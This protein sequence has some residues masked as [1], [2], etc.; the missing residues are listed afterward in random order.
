MIRLKFDACVWVLAIVF[1]VLTGID[2]GAQAE[3][4]ISNRYA[5]N[6]AGCHSP[7]RNNLPLK[8]RRCTLSCQGC[9][10]SPNGGGIRN[11]YGQWNQERWL[12]TFDSKIMT[13][14]L[15][16]APIKDQNY[17]R[18]P[19]KAMKSRKKTRP[20][21]R[22]IPFHQVNEKL[23]DRYHDPSYE[24]MVQDRREY[25]SRIPK[26]DPIFEEKRRRV[27]G[28]GDLRY[29][30]DA[31]AGRD[32]TGWM[33]AAD[34]GVRVRPIEDHLQLVL[35]SRFL[36]GPSNERIEQGFTSS[37]RAKTA[38]I[39]VDDLPYNSYVLGGLYRPMFGHYDANHTALSP[40]VTGLGQEALFQGVSVGASPNVPFANVHYIG[41][42]KDDDYNKAKGFIV[43]AGG[44]FVT[45]GGS[46][47]ISYWNTK[48]TEAT[49]IDRD[50]EMFAISGGGQLGP[51]NFTFEALRVELA[52][53]TQTD[54]G[55][56]YSL[57]LKYPVWRSIYLTA[58]G[59][60]GNI[61]RS[62]GEGD[63]NEY[64]MGIKAFPV[65][66]TEFE[67]MAISRTET[68]VSRSITD[69]GM[70]A[71]IHVFF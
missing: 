66:G 19:K 70:Q 34:L 36:N 14:K 50:R 39:Y 2:H 32:L 21:L 71:Q 26:V 20:R 16:P 48:G 49:G 23:Y 62:V 10:V 25:L 69:T 13:S 40:S 60:I 56:V 65:V 37:A 68:T 15:T 52:T 46:I 28:G 7:G 17:A 47:M 58:N 45:M 29:M 63:A 57:W 67:V 35:E 9:H 44:R 59:A 55:N 3:P 24:V 42:M 43:N 27:I 18:L 61:N 1:A 6:C 5:Q 12:K 51:L 4:W 31:T 22:T 41:P 64:G 8:K 30:M 38:M 33:M 11:L 54:K 53:G